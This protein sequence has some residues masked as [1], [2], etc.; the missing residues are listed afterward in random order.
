MYN[1]EKKVALFDEAAL[2]GYSNVGTQMVDYLEAFADMLIEKLNPLGIKPAKDLTIFVNDNHKHWYRAQYRTKYNLNLDFDGVFDAKL[3]DSNIS[4][5]WVPNMGSLD[6]C[7]ASP[8]GNIQ[9]IEYIPGEMFSVYF[10]RRLNNV[11]A[12]ATWKEGTAAGFAGKL[13]ATQALLDHDDHLDQQWIWAPKPQN[14]VVADATTLD[15]SKGVWHGTIA[16]T[17]ATN[18]TDIL[19][20]EVGVMYTIEC[21]ALADA[22]T[23]NKAGNFDQI[24]ADYAPAAIGD[25]LV[26]VKVGAKFYEVC[27]V[28]NEVLSYNALIAPNAIGV[29]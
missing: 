7:F 5:T 26:V 11:Y 27:R 17:V 1:T 12:Q 18:L 19:N 8:P 9:T 23:V 25:R 13:V 29:R 16:N 2:Y 3:Q 15:A 24:T 4:L 14:L 28:V 10:E 20:S 22:S 6:W 21:T